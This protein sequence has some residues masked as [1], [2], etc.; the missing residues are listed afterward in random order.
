MS[1]LEIMSPLTMGDLKLKNRLVLAPLTRAR[2]PTRVP[3]ELNALYYAQRASGGLLISEGTE[4]SVEGYGWGHSPGIYTDEQAAGWKIVTDAVHKKNGVIFCQLW[5]L[6]R[7]SHSSYHPE[8]KDIVSSSAVAVPDSPSTKATH[9]DGSKVPYEVPRAL[10]TKEIPRVV[11]DFRAAAARAKAA[12]FDGVEIHGANG[13]LLDQFCQSCVNSRDDKY[14]GSFENRA[15]LSMEVIAAIKTVF[16]ANRIG[17]RISP[18]GAFGGMGSADNFEFF[19]YFAAQLAPLGLAYLHVM[20]GLG[21]GFHDKCKRV[22]LMDIRS[23]YPGIII[24]NVGLTKEI[25][26][27]LI[28]GGVM[29]LAC[30]GRLYMSNPDLAERFA[31]DWPLADPAPY[32]TWWTRNL[33]AKGYTDWPTYT[34]PTD[35]KRQ[36]Q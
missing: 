4:P 32:P 19:T 2:C 1:T 14:G 10:E 29:D 24:G 13:Y 35:E 26:E 36:V 21:F 22:R 9:A 3:T 12:G 20:D 30:F 5:H 8:T 15:R 25:S 7:Q 6:G 28:R 16:P 11:E 31:N 27:G 23:V 34:P 17:Y 18:N 33:G